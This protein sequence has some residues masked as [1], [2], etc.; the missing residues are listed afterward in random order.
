MTAERSPAAYV[1]NPNGAYLIHWVGDVAGD[2][3]EDENFDAAAA[4]KVAKRIAV[5]GARNNGFGGAVRWTKHDGYWLLEMT[6]IPDDSDH[7]DG[8][9]Y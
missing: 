1:L 2:R 4:L 8:F 3:A 6:V 7:D 5:E 9:G